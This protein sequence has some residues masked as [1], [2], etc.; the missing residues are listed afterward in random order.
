MRACCK[1]AL[2]VPAVAREA[3]S[4]AR[5][6][7]CRAENLVCI[8]QRDVS[9]AT[10]ILA[11]SNSAVFAS[12]RPV[13][14]LKEAFVRIGLTQVKNLII[15]S[16]A[17]ASMKKMPLEQEWLREILLKHG[18]ATAT[19]A[20]Y[21]NRAL[22]LGFQG[23][24]FSAGLLHDVGRMLIAAVRPQ[25][26]ANADSMDFCEV[27]NHLERER[28]VL[29]TDHCVIGAWFA[30]Q[31]DL[32][33]S[34]AHAIEHHH[35]P[36]RSHPDQRLIALTA[37]ADHLANHLQ[38]FDEARG[39]QPAKNFAIVALEKACGKPI[40]KRF[41]DAAEQILEETLIDL[42]CSCRVSEF[43]PPGGKP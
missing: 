22:S 6:P 3:L 30:Q 21:L 5:D 42:S 4:I 17:V 15:A 10:E 28:K 26:F 27:E 24:E 31:Q 1:D 16:T 2:V 19:A 32:P 18:L 14:N 12:T 20:V 36:E 11:L 7:E 41:A 33:K 8:V 9:L 29:E 13:V 38:R 40:A 39:Y 43:P 23:E 25:C 37:A 34:L 35:H